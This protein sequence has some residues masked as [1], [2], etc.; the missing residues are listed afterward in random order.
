MSIGENDV[1]P[2]IECSIKHIVSYREE[3]DLSGMRNVMKL[4]LGLKRKFLS[5]NRFYQLGTRRIPLC[6]SKEQHI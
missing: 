4:R 1:K 3:L 2:I 5:L 6:P